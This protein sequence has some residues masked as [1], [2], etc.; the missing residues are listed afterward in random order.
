[1]L[2]AIAV[3]VCAVYV[4]FLYLPAST[5]L[6][7]IRDQQ[8]QL[9]RLLGTDVGARAGTVTDLDGD[10]SPEVGGDERFLHLLPCL[11]VEM[12]RAQ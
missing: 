9:Q 12:T 8:L 7:G 11:V 10:L 5:T 1:M 3:L 6:E 4:Y 2:P